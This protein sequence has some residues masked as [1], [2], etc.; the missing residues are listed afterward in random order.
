MSGVPCGRSWRPRGP[1][2]RRVHRRSATGRCWRLSR[3]QRCQS[4]SRDSPTLRVPASRSHDR[5]GGRCCQ[6]RIGAGRGLWSVSTSREPAETYVSAG[7]RSLVHR[8]ITSRD[9]CLKG[10][11]ETV[12]QSHF[13]GT[14]EK[15]TR[16]GN[17]NRVEPAH[18]R[19]RRIQPGAPGGLS[20][21][22]PKGRLS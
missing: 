22:A 4:G 7:S 10:R 6:S 20:S 17:G 3:V 16:R 19:R 2:S 8:K 12:A 5:S 1:S 15:L 13:I 11:T 14:N 18:A 9:A 21:R